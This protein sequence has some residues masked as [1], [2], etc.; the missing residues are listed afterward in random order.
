M[1]A[2]MQD[3]IGAERVA[4]PHIELYERM[5]RRKATFKHQAHRIA[6]IAERWL[7][8]DKDI[9]EILAK[10]KDAAAIG[11]NL[12]GGRAPNSLDRFERRRVANDG[13]GIDKGRHI[14]RLAISCRIALQYGRAQ[15]INGFRHVDGI[16]VCLHAQHRVM[17]TFKHA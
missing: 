10:D 17:Q 6:F 12:A 16:A 7:Q 13:I 11:L 14:A 3:H 2:K 15:I 8:P 9:A 5:R 4:Q 1:H